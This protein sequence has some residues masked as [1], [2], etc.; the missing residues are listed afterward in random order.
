MV[1]DYY[2]GIL[3]AGNLLGSTFNFKNEL[4]DA[5]F[6]NFVHSF[7][8]GS[9]RKNGWKKEGEIE[10][11]IERLLKEPPYKEPV[12]IAY[13]QWQMEDEKDTT[14]DEM[15][16]YLQTLYEGLDPDILKKILPFVRRTALKQ[17]P[18]IKDED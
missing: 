1:S 9:Y 2:D 6:V 12:E 10:R 15:A 11:E 16:E 18:L 3:M 5:D 4:E 13:D 7:K 14:V 8:S 17:L